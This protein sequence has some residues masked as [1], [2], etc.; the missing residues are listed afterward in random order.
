MAFL[1]EVQIL[2]S[3]YNDRCTRNGKT[4]WN[5]VTLVTVFF[6]SS[7]Q[8]SD[9]PYYIYRILYISYCIYRI[10]IVLLF[11][12]TITFVA[13][14]YRVFNPITELYSQIQL[15]HFTVVINPC[16]W[17]L[18][19]ILVFKYCAYNYVAFTHFVYLQLLY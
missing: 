16:I 6:S 12:V 7:A 14:N 1:W 8:K 13:I 11:L 3:S 19:L 4:C 10:K 17:P 9:Y 18:Y 15:S 5:Y 2:V